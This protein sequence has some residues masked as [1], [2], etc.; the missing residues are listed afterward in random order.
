MA[1]IAFFILI[2]CSKSDS[3]R[4]LVNKEQGDDNVYSPFC[5]SSLVAT[6]RLSCKNFQYP[7]SAVHF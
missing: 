2:G 3:L 7:Q 4:A 5:Y 6:L 1:L